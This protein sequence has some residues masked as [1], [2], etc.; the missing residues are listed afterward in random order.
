MASRIPRGARKLVAA[1][2]AR[3]YVACV[4]DQLHILSPVAE[5]L[6]ERGAEVKLIVGPTHLSIHHPRIERIDILSAREMY[7]ACMT[8]FPQCD[9]AILSAAVADFRPANA[10]D[11]K[12][13]KQNDTDGMTLQLVQNPDILA[14]LGKSKQAHQVLVGFAL[15]TNNEIAHAQTKLEKKNL[16]FIVLNSLRDKGAGFGTDTNKITIIQRDG[17]IE[18]GTLKTKREVASDIV[19]KLVERLSR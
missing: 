10:S 5:T 11:I 1:L 15:E 13:K 3:C 18:E 2:R 8:H 9:G 16:D 6:A 4:W 19:D 14:S 12:I 7:D 17:T